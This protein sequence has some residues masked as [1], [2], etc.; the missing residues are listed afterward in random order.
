MKNLT[1]FL[2]LLI[3]SCAKKV[4][5]TNLDI[6]ENTSIPTY[7][8]IAKDSFSAGATSVDVARKIRVSS[9]IYQDS[10]RENLKKIEAEKLAKKEAEEK[11]NAQKKIAEEKK[12]IEE[13]TKAKKEKSAIEILP[14]ENAQNP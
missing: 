9:K 10:L 5:E 13:E 4:N 14:T 1:V 11:E 2:L 6:D 12:K 7:D 3:I 8:T